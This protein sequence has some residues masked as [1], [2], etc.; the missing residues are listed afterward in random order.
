MVAGFVGGAALSAVQL[1][2]FLEYS[3]DSEGKRLREAD[4]DLYEPWV[5]LSWGSVLVG[6]CIVVALRAFS[7][8]RTAC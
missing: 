4:I 3:G 5:S 2:P 8:W 1:L 7:W 6:L